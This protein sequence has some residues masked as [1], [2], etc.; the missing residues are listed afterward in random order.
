MTNVQGLYNHCRLRH[1]REF[2]SHDECIRASAV[3][4]SPEEEAWV[5]E[6][7]IELPG[8]SLPSLRSLFEM[9]VGA[10]MVDSGHSPSPAPRMEGSAPVDAVVTSTHLSRTLGHH[11]DTPALAPFLGREAK[12]RNITV[13]AEDVEVDIENVPTSGLRGWRKP[14][15][16][17]SKAVP[18]LDIASP[19]PESEQEPAPAPSS[20]MVQPSELQPSPSVP[21]TGSRFHFTARVTI[22]D[23]SLWLPPGMSAS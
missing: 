3:K 14:Y 4:V 12:R 13:L 18:A 10:E 2:G 19:E 5:I 22:G 21:A 23:R 1:K 7:G 15:M 20:A 17:R 9:A 6:N 11:I 16:H 8:V